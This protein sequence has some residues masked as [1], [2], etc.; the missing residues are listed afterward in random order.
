MEL[1][2]EDGAPEFIASLFPF[3]SKLKI[4]SFYVVVVQG[5]QR[6]VQKSRRDAR[7]ELLFCSLT[8]CLF[9]VADTV[10]V[11]VLKGPLR[12]HNGDGGENVT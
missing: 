12:Y 4:W 10:A 5:Q 11:A 9:D 7:A 1:K 8:Y 2:R 3:L 6:N